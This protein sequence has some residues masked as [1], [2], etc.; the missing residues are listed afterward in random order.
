MNRGIRTLAVV[1]VLAAGLIMADVGAA[2]A[3]DL[4]NYKGSGV[5]I[6]TG[7]SSSYTSVGLGY[8]GNG[9][10]AD[11]YTSGQ[12]VGGDTT[13]AHHR[14]LST[15]KIGYSADYYLTWNIYPSPC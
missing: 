15:G 4:G 1:P 9:V 11:F 2:H 6:R 8:P 14:N 7:P 5:K 3:G 10:C 12:N 13:W